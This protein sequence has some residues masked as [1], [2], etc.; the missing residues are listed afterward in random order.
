MIEPPV[1]A[2]TEHEQIRQAMEHSF[3]YT[4]FFTEEA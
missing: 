3:L 1:L 4:S 2:R